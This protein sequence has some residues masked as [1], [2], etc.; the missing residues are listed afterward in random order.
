MA[1]QNSSRL[2]HNR[3]WQ[4][5]WLGQAISITGDYVFDTTLVLW[6]SV[7]IAKGEPWAPAAVGGVLIAAAVPALLVG[8]IAGVFVDRWSRRRTM[9]TADACRALLVLAVLPLAWPSVADHVSRSARIAAIYLVVAAASCFAQ[10]FNPS[11]FA[12]LG[13]VVDQQD[14][15]RA[16]GLFQATSSIAA[17]VGPP[18]AAPLL[19]VFG[20]QWALVINAASFLV[21]FVT[22][23][24]IRMAAE[25]VTPKHERAGY[26]EEFRAGLRFFAG[27]PVLIAL[28]VGVI[29]TTLG[30]GAV[31]ALNVF[32]VSHNLHVGVKWYGTLGSG[33]GIGSVL[34]ALVAGWIANRV[35][36]GRVFWAGLIV[37]GVVLVGYS[38]SV[39]LPTAI[40]VLACGGV[41]V[42]AV[43][44]VLSPLVLDVTPQ[45]MLGRVVAVV[46][47][48]QQLAAIL[49]MAVSGFLASTVLR[50]FH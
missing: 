20:V 29:V 37:A 28:A 6:V 26:V 36:A 11:R 21:S 50:N 1:E 42:G 34:G 4:L 44:T 16:S 25:K 45:E 8:P 9:L 23:R 32:F 40:V 19:F 17:I 43:N 31:N 13:S 5:L 38:R 18:L 47:P 14:R 22:I 7:I 46:S 49:S 2:R 30:V 41:A 10:F 12:V 39:T 48:L 35:G 24:A 33:E 3:N 27:S 15:A